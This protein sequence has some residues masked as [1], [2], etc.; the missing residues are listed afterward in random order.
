MCV[1]ARVR[2]PRRPISRV[3]VCT[4]SND[5][6]LYVRVCMQLGAERRP[7]SP[8]SNQ[9]V[10]HITPL[11]ANDGHDHSAR[12][13]GA[14]SGSDW[15]WVSG[16]VCRSGYLI[17]MFSLL[18]LTVRAFAAAKAALHKSAGM[19]FVLKRWMRRRGRTRT[20]ITNVVCM[21][22]CF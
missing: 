20:S 14:L 2:R 6:S 22:M 5:V 12:G 21:C 17:I 15:K 1:Y 18:L 3:C 13:I 9:V 4:S 19:M 16:Q 10:L 11:N 8:S 7:R